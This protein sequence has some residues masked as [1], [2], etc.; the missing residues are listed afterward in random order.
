MCVCVCVCVCACVCVCLKGRITSEL[1]GIGAQCR[2][3]RHDQIITRQREALAEL[4]SRVKVLEQSKAPG[5]FLVVGVV[6]VLGEGGMVGRGGCVGMVGGGGWGGQR[7]TLTELRS[8]VKMLE[9]FKA[10]GGF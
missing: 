10:P 8:R 2:G 4:R 6:A 5:R 7:E 1:V 9:Q 3:E